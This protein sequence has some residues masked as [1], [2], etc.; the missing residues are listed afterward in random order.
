MKSQFNDHNI[1]DILNANPTLTEDTNN[2]LYK[3]NL[4]HNVLFLLFM[5]V[6][7]YFVELLRGV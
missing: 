1:G 7:H 3:I 5:V 4:L 6:C 2:K